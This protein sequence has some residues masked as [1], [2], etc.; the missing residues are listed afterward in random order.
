MKQQQLKQPKYH[1]KE[2]VAAAMGKNKP[3]LTVIGLMQPRAWKLPDGLDNQ[4][5]SENSETTSYNYA[6]DLRSC[7]LF[8]SCD[9]II[10]RRTWSDTGTGEQKWDMK[11]RKEKKTALYV[12]HDI[13]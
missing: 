1:N 4:S 6:S 5:W 9:R 3:I 12:V 11:K 7:T 13:C 10:D 2:F 8:F